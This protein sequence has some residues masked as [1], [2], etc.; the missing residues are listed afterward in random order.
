M[1]KCYYD[2]DLC[3]S[4]LWECLTCGEYYCQTHFHE[5]SKGRNVECV[6]CEYQR[7][8]QGAA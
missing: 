6:V 7:Q 5:T 3:E 8:A 2:N 4:D 1:D